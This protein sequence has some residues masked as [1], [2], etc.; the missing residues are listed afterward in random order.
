MALVSLGLSPAIVLSVSVPRPANDGA[1][2][3]ALTGGYCK[4]GDLSKDKP[5]LPP[6]AVEPIL[7]LRIREASCS[8][9]DDLRE[10]N[11]WAIL[12]IV[13]VEDDDDEEEEECKWLPGVPCDPVAPPL[14]SWRLSKRCLI[15]PVFSLANGI[16]S[17]ESI[18]E[19]DCNEE[20]N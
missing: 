7:S 4:V 10:W 2:S 6:L 3:A 19:L 8:D 12:A 11:E 18:L 1:L 16:V 17:I 5:A 9:D 20:K 15:V 13:F 14:N